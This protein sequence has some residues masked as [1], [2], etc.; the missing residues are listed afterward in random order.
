MGDEICMFCV[1]F[2]NILLYYPKHSIKL[3]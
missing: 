3:L 2:D 1:I